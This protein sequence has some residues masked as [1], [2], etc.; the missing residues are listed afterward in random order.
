VPFRAA[1]DCL[2]C[3]RPA[4][5]REDDLGGWAQL[6]A[7]CLGRAG[8]NAFLRGRL[9]AALT[10]RTGAQAAPRPTPDRRAPSDL[11]AQTRAYYAARAPEYDDWYQRRGRYSHGPIH[12]AA[13][14][15]ELDAAGRWLDALPIKGEIVE[16]AA[17]TGWWSPLLAEKGELSLY[18]ANE[19]PLERARERLVAHSLRAHL[20]VRDAWAA[21]DRRVDAVFAGF[22]LSH[23]PRGRLDAFLRVARDWLRPGG[24]FAAI[25][26]LPDPQSGAAD[27]APPADG[28]SLRRLA[29][30]REFT[31]VKVLYTPE[32]L[33][34][35]LLRAG[36]ATAEATTTGRFFVLVNAT[37]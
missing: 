11:E 35:A 30:G 1:F 25:D 14:N 26:G 33:R 27:Q 20:H 3:G 5:A 37:V 28:R 17:G 18:D 6:C 24:R 29:D 7:D 15:A 32:E 10:E 21:P 19:E 36:F 12:D 8:D 22:W 2:W 4:T 34:A 16:L 13:W 9:R 23:V 31:I